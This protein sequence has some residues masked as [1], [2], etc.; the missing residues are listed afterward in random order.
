MA[1]Q[2]LA[3]L[4]QSA[5]NLQTRKA[6]IVTGLQN[7]FI[8]PDGKLPVNTESGFVDRL[9][10]LVPDFRDFG[11]VIWVR[12]EFEAN[13]AVNGLD[14]AGDSVIAGPIARDKPRQEDN[15]DR[16]SPGPFKRQRLSEDEKERP[17]ITHDAVA[18]D[19]D[20]RQAGD[21]ERRAQEEVDEELF[22]TRTAHKE[23]CC[24]RGSIGAEYAAPI[25]DL[26][27]GKRDMQLVKTHYSAFSSTSLLLTLRSK[28]VTELFVCGCTTNLSVYATAMDAARHG[29]KVT[30]VEDCLGYR[31]KDRHD[32][33]IAQLRG[34]MEADVMTSTEVIDI[35]RNPPPSPL[36]HDGDEDEDEDNYAVEEE[37]IQDA[38]KLLEVDSEGEDEDEVDLV[39][40]I[41]SLQFS[42]RR[43]TAGSHGVPVSGRKR[44]SSAE[45]SEPSSSRATNTSYATL[46]GF[47]RTTEPSRSYGKRKNSLESGFM[48]APSDKGLATDESSSTGNR[49]EPWLNLID[50]HWAESSSKPSI[51]SKHPGLAAISTLA[52]LDQKTVDEYEEMVDEEVQ[53]RTSEDAPRVLVSKPL[54]GE[55]KEQE[56][57]GS[58]LW[59]DLLPP[60]QAD[61][62]FDELKDEVTW[63]RMH[64][65][66]GEVPRL[67]CCQGSVE[68]DGSMPVYRHPSDQT[69]PI[70]SWTF[71][72]DEV[73]KAA[74]EVVGHP[75]NHALIQLYR[76]GIDFIS[77]HSDKT[78]D[79]V[80][81]SFIVNVSFGA[82]RTMRLRT[83]RASAGASEKETPAQRTTYRVP[84][85]HN[86]M[87][88]MSLATNAEYLHGINADK[89][90]SVELTEAEKA[91]GGQRISLTFRHIGT[92][93]NSDSSRICGQGATGKTKEEA[94][95]VI[96]GD[97]VESE[98]LVRAFGAENQSSTLCWDVAYGDGS[99]VLHLK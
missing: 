19:V 11:D 26:I 18:E 36:D 91:H 35:L 31:R 97:T 72:V 73:R 3:M 14:E 15:F 87:I 44:S 89:R 60:E 79:V 27:D 7:D 67:V 77:E 83:K 70:Q 6:L 33:A 88:S 81:D 13:R 90:P 84:M 96:N 57:A 8:S 40:D 5:P 17:S 74:E 51:Q 49:K 47:S 86:S 43:N 9:Q 12:S 59:Y 52:G 45:P 29:I 24:I 23:P 56:S 95:D 10:A 28:L 99:D 50:R 54:F 39:R 82:Q 42:P 68:D 41:Y 62:I 76:G 55:D 58:K 53:R 71:K 63:Q 22:L 64:H 69:L 75:L 46:D 92:F 61:K 4:S 1:A 20:T 66:T 98:K 85:P 78:L 94:K 21:V 34:I 48:Q 37:S 16:D 80:K 2:L 25:K 30:L 65:Q 38:T 93:L 32:L